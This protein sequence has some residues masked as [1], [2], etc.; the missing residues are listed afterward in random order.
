M[1]KTNAFK[2]AE[3]I[4]VFSYDTSGDVIT[5]SK[6]LDTKQRTSS[7][8][9]TYI[10][11]MSSG[12]DFHSTEIVLVHDGSAV[13]MTQ[14]GTLKSANLATFDADIS[15]SDAR[16]RVTPAS[17]SSTTIKFHRVLVGA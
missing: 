5:T 6:E 3:L 7:S 14:Y 16:L 12:S 2:I 17:S 1:A 4:R 10:V 9:T 13:T 15:G 11:A 8:L